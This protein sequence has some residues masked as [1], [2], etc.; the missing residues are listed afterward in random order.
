MN[1]YEFDD[2]IEQSINDIL[3]REVSKQQ[4]DDFTDSLYQIVREQ[5]RQIISSNFRRRQ[6]PPRNNVSNPA[7]INLILFQPPP[8]NYYYQPQTGNYL[9]QPYM[10]PTNPMLQNSMQMQQNPMQSNP[11]LQNSIQQN[12]YN[13]NKKET[14]KKKPKKIKVCDFNELSLKK[15]K[16][17]ISDN[18]I[19]K[20]FENSYK[21]F[22]YLV[23]LKGISDKE[24]YLEVVSEN[25]KENINDNSELKK[26][27]ISWKLTNILNENNSIDSKLS[28]LL[29]PFEEVTVEI[30]YP[31]SSYDQTYNSVLSNLKYSNNKIKIAIFISGI[32]RTDG[33]FFGNKNIDE[34]KF[35]T[36]V[37]E[38]RYEGAS[39]AFQCCSNLKKVTIP[40]TVTEIGNFSFQFCKSLNHVTIPSSVRLLGLH[41]FEGCTSLSDVQLPYPRPRM[42][43]DVFVRCPFRP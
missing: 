31:S 25:Q 43:P 2:E 22:S 38:I 15:Q 26:L 32:S 42:E 36:T 19:D 11:M 33:K 13:Q 5:A 24:R 1:E 34:V 12:P 16:S 10:M 28:E 39:G 30:K 6:N 3:G 7:A 20:K 4:I 40:S 27:F 17:S 9:M 8:Q 35:D 37:R 18:K 21:L 23:K 14:K 41:A 29:R